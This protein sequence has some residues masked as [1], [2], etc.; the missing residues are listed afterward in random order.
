MEGLG[1]KLFFFFLF[2]M[3]G[4]VYSYIVGVK[5]LVYFYIVEIFN[6]L[7]VFRKFNLPTFYKIYKF[8][9]LF[10]FIDYEIPFIFHPLAVEENK[11]DVPLG[12]TIK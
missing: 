10:L 4:L 7:I 1:I 11:F 12:T 9:I 3:N 8:S 2:I 6:L 5:G